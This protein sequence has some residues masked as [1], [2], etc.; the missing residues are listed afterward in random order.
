MQIFEYSNTGNREVNQDFLLHRS[1]DKDKHLFIIADGMGGYSAGDSAAKLVSESI[2]EFVNAHV[3]E[4]SPAEVLKDAIVFS[5]EELS[6][7]R[8]AYGG[9]QMGTVIVVLLIC[10]D[11][12]YTSWLG[13][14]RLY[15]YRAGNKIFQSTDH[16]LINDI[17]KI[18][19]IKPKDIERY[20][21]V[22]TRCIMGDDR[23]G[24]INVIQLNVQQGDVFFLCSDGLHKEI[25]PNSLPLN[26][27]VLK[28]LLDARNN[29]FQDNYSLI[30]ISV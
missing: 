14:S 5:N 26:D 10:G 19:F 6:F 20:S 16:S 21:S 25:E 15:Q 18:H 24:E 13:D 8:Y 9:A 7:Q 30:K 23:L 17:K 1:I 2:F 12:A 11:T 28:A 27:A 3:S 4:Q 22:V 29:K